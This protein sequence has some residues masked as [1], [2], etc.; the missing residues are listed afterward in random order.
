MRKIQDL[1][2][3]SELK[4]NFSQNTLKSILFDWVFGSNP[5]ILML[6]ITFLLNCDKF[7]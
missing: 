3:N 6:L 4:G 7:D 2:E 1:L 5:F